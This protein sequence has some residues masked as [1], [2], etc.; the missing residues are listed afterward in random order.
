MCRKNWVQY[1]SECFYYNTNTLNIADAQ[2]YCETQGGNLASIISSGARDTIRNM[3]STTAHIG[4]TDQDSEGSWVWADGT[5]VSYTSW[6]S[7]EPSSDYRYNCAGIRTDAGW[8]DYRC[9]D[10]RV[11]VCKAPIQY[12][13]T[14]TGCYCPFDTTRMDC[15][16]CVSGGTHCGVDYIDRCYQSG[17]SECASAEPLDDWTV[18][19]KVVK[20]STTNVRNL[21]EGS[22][23]TNDGSAT[24]ACLG[25][26]SYNYKT[27]AANSFDTNSVKQVKVGFFHGGY[28][29]KS[30]TFDSS[31]TTRTGFFSSSQLIYAPYTD[32][33]TTSMNYFSIAGHY[34]ISRHFFVSRAYGGCSVDSGWF[35]VVDYGNNAGCNWDTWWTRPYFIAS[36]AST[37]QTWNSGSWTY[38]DIFAILYKYDVAENTDM[39]ICDSGWTNMGNACYRAVLEQKSWFD[40]LDACRNLRTDADLVSILDGNENLQTLAMSRRTHTEN[41]YWIGL[42]DLNSEDSWE[43]SDGSTN[44]YTNWNSNEPNNSN[45][46]ENCAAMRWSEDGSWNDAD[47]DTTYYFI[48][49][50]PLVT[51]SCAEWKRKGYSSS[52]YYTVDPDGRNNG[53]DPFRVYC[54]MSSDGSTGIARIQHNQEIR[55]RISGY[56]DPLSYSLGVRYEDVSYTQAAVL[57]DISNECYQYIKWECKGSTMD[58]DYTAWYDRDGAKISYWG[59]A[60]QGTDYCQCGAQGNCVNGKICQCSNNDQTWRTDDGYLTYKDDL[61]VTKINFGDTGDSS[62]E[63]YITLGSLYC[64][65]DVSYMVT[66]RTDFMLIREAHIDGFNNLYISGVDQN[67]CASTCA[68]STDFTCRSFDYKPST[69]ECWLSEE[70]DKT[71]ATG[72]GSTYHLFVR[73]FDRQENQARASDSCP[74]SWA[75]YNS[76]CYRFYE[77]TYSW[78]DAEVYCQGQGGHLA[79]P[80]DEAE[81]HLL[82]QTARWMNPTT[83]AFWIGV[84]DVEKEGLWTDPEGNNITYSR[85]RSSE[86]N[87]DITENAAL[88]YAYTSD[89]YIDATVENSRYFMCKVAV[90]ASAIA[91]PTHSSCV[92]SW[93]Y[94][95]DLHS[96]YYFSSDTKTFDA[97]RTSCQAQ[98]ADLVVIETEAEWEYLIKSYRYRYS[99]RN[100]WIGLSDADQE[101]S[102]KYVND[103][104]YLSVTSPFWGAN[105]PSDSGSGEDCAVL[106][107]SQLLND[108]DCTTSYY[109]ICEQDLYPT[110]PPTNLHVNPM[111][112]TSALVTWEDPP[113]SSHQNHDV[114]GYKIIYRQTEGDDNATIGDVTD[115]AIYFYEATGLSPGSDYQFNIL[116]YTTEGDGPTMVT[117]INI[118]MLASVTMTEH[119][120]FK[121]YLIY[122]G[123]RLQSN[124]LYTVWALTLNH[125]TNLCTSD[126]RCLSVNYRSRADND[127]KDCDINGQ[128]HVGQEENLLEDRDYIHAGVEGM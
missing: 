104:S 109:Y 4:F 123:Y 5:S 84:N 25:S 124:T 115:G 70:N 40:A 79:T 10:T 76:Y 41:N 125:C 18:M 78:Y 7:G 35:A 100:Y 28:E 118:T 72:S 81:Y 20:S 122:D 46:R 27:S 80:Q 33:Y 31:G 3:I 21:W 117:P 13:A 75:E 2:A 42:N 56:E 106:T 69:N 128:T 38:P 24:A 97:A 89:D 95:S 61:P 9:S 64:K 121:V 96:C 52:A 57:A 26:T 114:A 110:A 60:T 77:S 66:T 111:T 119:A 32:I 39:D 82:R 50:Y 19:M 126:S 73:I 47:C 74:S 51:A 45:D 16:C 68:D 49:K 62:E 55:T 14:T 127:R 83:A 15:A 92:S 101:G 120:R 65:G 11:S 63:G 1:G 102:F 107:T 59:G 116:A 86:P 85:W 53:Q 44:S 58:A 98:N 108:A 17:I 48:C 12:T 90:G 34:S 67:S 36:T 88:M 71:Q 30:L 91:Q 54:D 29:M 87:G 105:Q 94:N 22:D 99:T 6:A 112:P 43:W 93:S 103:V 113:Q 37:Y 8:E 23:T